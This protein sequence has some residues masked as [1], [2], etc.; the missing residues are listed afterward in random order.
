MPECL[1]LLPF[2]YCCL[3]SWT[4]APIPLLSPAASTGGCC[5]MESIPNVHLLHNQPASKVMDGSGENSYLKEKWILLYTWYLDKENVS[6]V[7]H[8][9]SKC[10]HASLLKLGED[11]PSWHSGNAKCS[12]HWHLV[13]NWL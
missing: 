2:H 11:P 12:F 4:G 13:L 10:S 6:T 8:I 3:P 9:P 1:S 5:G 7:R